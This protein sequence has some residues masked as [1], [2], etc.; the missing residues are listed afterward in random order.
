MDMDY[1]EEQENPPGGIDLLI[2]LCT[3]PNI[4][5][6]SCGCRFN[7]RELRNLNKLKELHISGLGDLSH[8]EDANEVQLMSKTH[9][10]LLALDF[11]CDEWECREEKCRSMLQQNIKVSHERLE[12]DFTYEEMWHE[13]FHQFQNMLTPEGFTSP[14]KD[15]LES[16]RPHTGLRKLIIE[17][18]DCQSYPSWLGNASFSVFTEIELSGSG[19]ERQHVPTLGELPLLKSLKIG[20]M[21][22]VEHIG[23]EFC[24]Y[25]S[26]IKAYPSLTSLE[27]FLMPRCSEWSGVEDGDF[28]CL[29]T[30]S[31]KWCFKLSYL[32]LERFP[33]LE[34]VTL[35]DCDGINTIPAGRTFKKLCIEECR[36]LNTVPTQPSLL[37]LELKNCPKLSTVGFMPG[38]NTLEIMKCPN[39][40]TVDSMPELKYL[41]ACGELEYGMLASLLDDAPL[42]EFL[43]I[44]SH[45]LTSIPLDRKRLPSLSRIELCF[46]DRLE[47]C[48]GLT[49]FTSLKSLVIRQCP[50]LPPHL[51]FRRTN[52]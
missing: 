51:K 35:H 41:R 4:F 47:Y 50:L 12:L 31:V 19:C 32:P 49:G 28:A 38:L 17:N 14:H 2:N 7:L 34:T 46:C 15:L 37:V 33:S 40:N 18:Y 1:L 11:S 3:L 23:R 26:G 6:R 43:Y 27:M 13:K 22:F 24:S 30:L 36:G 8:I 44:N 48:E 39:L 9:L 52:Q 10:Q 21:S 45:T 25:V 16:L 5:I 20:S 29:K 42:L